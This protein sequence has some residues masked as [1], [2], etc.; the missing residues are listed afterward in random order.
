MG[1]AV[2]APLA[3]IFTF[4]FVPFA[5]CLS[6]SSNSRIDIF[7]FLMNIYYKDIYDDKIVK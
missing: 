1:R 2:W 6:L 7:D 4:R 3:W 5:T